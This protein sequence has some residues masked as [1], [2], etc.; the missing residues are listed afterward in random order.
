VASGSQS[1]LKRRIAAHEGRSDVDTDKE[2]LTTLARRLAQATTVRSA[3]WTLDDEDVFT[4]AAEQGT[5]T[6]ASRDRD[7]EPPYELSVYRPDRQKIDEL[8]SALIDDD[9]PAPWND[10][11]VELYWA[12]RRSALGADD[13]IDA[14]IEALPQAATQGEDLRRHSLLAQAPGVPTTDDGT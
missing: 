1:N 2:R 9:R 7:N 3:H 10:A 6:I 14:L 13:I 12:A 8:S 5:V 11:L 4:W